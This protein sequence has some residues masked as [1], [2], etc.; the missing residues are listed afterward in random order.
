AEKRIGHAGTLDPAATGVLPLAVGAARKT[1]EF[2]AEASKTYDAE[3]T[4]GIE[5]DTWDRDGAVVA[6][7][8]AGDLTRGQIEAALA[9]FR[10]AFAQTPPM[11]SAIKIG[12]RKLYELAR[13]GE[14]IE[15]PPRPVTIHALELL[16]WEP[17]VARLR[18]DCSKGT[19]IRSLAH[20]LGTALGPGAHLSALRRT[21]SGPFTLADA[22]TLDA[23]AAA[24]LPADW[25]RLALPPDA[26]LADW[27]ALRLD[28]EAATRWRQGRP[29]PAIQ[30]AAG[31]CRVYDNAGVW[32][33]I[34]EA[35]PDG[36]AWRPTKV[37]E[38]AA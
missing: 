35:T 28:P 26:P 6:T 37:V 14:E 31:R 11:H 32:L 29:V 17:P 21:R 7:A 4:F 15:R 19:Y 9:P 33:G 38:R 30:D 1:L 8:A 12:G 10:G 22:I 34:G 36:R 23:L 5:T 27:P 16:A 24:D 18:I 13:K 20:D 2:L 3:I 25:P